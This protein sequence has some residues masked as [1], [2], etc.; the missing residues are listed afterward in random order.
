VANILA[1]KRKAPNE[2]NPSVI[3]AS[4]IEARLTTSYA[5]KPS[6]SVATSYGIRRED[7]VKGGSRIPDKNIGVQTK[8]YRPNLQRFLQ[9]V[10]SICVPI[11][12]PTP[13]SLYVYSHHIRLQVYSKYGKTQAPPLNTQGGKQ[14]GGHKSKPGLKPGT[15]KRKKDHYS[16]Q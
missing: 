5:I 13:R 7:K 9:E 6:K 12:K 4:F 15:Q 16:D 10:P 14:K 8:G 11:P 1:V 2:R 3:E